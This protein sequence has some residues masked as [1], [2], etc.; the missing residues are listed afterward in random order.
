MRC[1]DVSGRPSI[2]TVMADC[3]LGPLRGSTKIGGGPSL[4]RGG[5]REQVSPLLADLVVGCAAR[6][7]LLVLSLYPNPPPPLATPPPPASA[8]CPILLVLVPS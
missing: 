2:G 1:Q 7:P 3:G 4:L 6:G 8:G 5:C